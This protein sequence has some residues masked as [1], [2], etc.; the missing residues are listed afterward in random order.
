MMNEAIELELIDLIIDLDYDGLENLQLIYTN[1]G[2]YEAAKIVLRYQ[3][4]LCEI[5][6]LMA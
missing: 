1:I 6:L 5:E 2:C 3:L 4:H